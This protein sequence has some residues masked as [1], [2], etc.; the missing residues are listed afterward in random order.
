MLTFTS[1][2][3]R[4]SHPQA[5]WLL[6]LQVLHPHTWPKGKERSRVKG[7]LARCYLEEI[8][9][10]GTFGI[11]DRLEEIEGLRKKEVIIMLTLPCGSSGQ[12]LGRLG[13]ASFFICS[14]AVYCYVFKLIYFRENVWAIL[15]NYN[16]T[17]T[18][19]IDSIV[20]DFS[21]QLWYED[22]ITNKRNYNKVIITHILRPKWSL[23]K[24]ISLNCRKYWNCAKD[25]IVKFHHCDLSEKHSE[26]KT[27]M[28]HVEYENN[29]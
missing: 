29:L 4:P 3:L 16:W 28:L 6:L 27:Y 23:S 5:R 11:S 9:S 13:I 20:N 14:I 15:S 12:I 24:H 8:Y 22:T 17:K 26:F 18:H 19:S 7:L 1:W 25:L 2:Y 10:P 21:R